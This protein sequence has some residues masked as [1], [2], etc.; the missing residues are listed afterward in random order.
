MY[1][2]IGKKCPTSALFCVPHKTEPMTLKEIKQKFPD[3][4]GL[5]DGEAKENTLSFYWK[6]NKHEK[7]FEFIDTDAEDEVAELMGVE[8]TE[9][10]DQ[11]ENLESRQLSTDEIHE[12]KEQIKEMQ[13]LLTESGFKK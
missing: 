4:I 3:F 10:A 9:F 7:V 6:W 2:D 5:F 1:L 11:E 13:E 12:F 8:I